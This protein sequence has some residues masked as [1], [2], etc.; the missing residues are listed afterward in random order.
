ME[1]PRGFAVFKRRPAATVACLTFPSDAGY[2][3]YRQQWADSMVS[4]V[5]GQ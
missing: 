5:Y 2:V 4:N 1:R 3:A